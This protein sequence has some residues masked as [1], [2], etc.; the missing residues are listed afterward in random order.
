MIFHW[1]FN[2]AVADSTVVLGD[3]Q[4]TTIIANDRA[5]YM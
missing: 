2:N 5:H 4:N 3:I 1:S